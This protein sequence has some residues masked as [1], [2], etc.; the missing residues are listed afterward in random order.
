MK[1]FFKKLFTL[2][3]WKRWF[4][5]FLSFFT[6]VFVISYTS[7]QYISKNINKSIE[8]GGGAEV[9][10]QVK[11]LDDKV[12][13]KNT[14][15]NADQ[16]IFTR[17]T[18][19]SG[20]NGTSVSIEGE[21][22]IR[23]SRN[24][25]TDNRKLESFISEIVTKPLLTITDA[26]NKPLFYDGKFVDNGSLDYGNEVN[27]APPFKPESAQ[28]RPNPNNPSQNEVQIEL[29]NTD[30]ELEWSKAT[31]YVSKKPFGKNRILIWS[32]I[33]GLIK[34]AK[35]QYPDEWKNAKE[36]VFNFVHVNENPNPAPLQ[37]NRPATPVL[38]QYQ[39]D[40]KKYLISDARVQQALN[41]S[42]FVINGNFSSAEAKQLALN[43]NFGT[44]DYKLD[45]LSASF[46]SQTKSDSAFTSAWIA[47]VVAISVIALFMIVN[48]GLL[49]VLSTISLALYIFLTLLFFTIVRGEYS[50]ITIA[51]LVIGIGMNVDANIISFEILKTKIYSGHTVNKSNAYANKSSLSTIL[52]SNITTLIAGLILF[53]FG[54]KSI[55]SFSITLIFS[56]IFTLLVIMLFT[57]LM[58]SLVLRT[59]FFDKRKYLLGVRSKYLQKYER[60]YTSVLDKP[61]YLAWNKYTR[62]IPLGMFILAILIFAIFAGI[63]QSFVGGLNLSIEFSGGTNIL[64]ENSDPTYDL[65]D[66]QK[67]EAIIKFL[68]QQGIKNNASQILMHPLNAEN[69]VF[70]IEI[71]TQQDLTSVIQNLNTNLAN[72]FSN[73]KFTTYSISTEEARSLILNAIL[74]V[75]VAI[76][77]VTAFAFI[78][79]KWTF[80][81]AIIVSLLFNVLMVIFTFIIFHV[82]LSP[83]IV[84]A[85]LSII[86][87][88]IN[89]TIVIFDKIK[90]IFRELPYTEV[91]DESRVKRIATQAI[92][93][94]IKRSLLTS[95]STIFA[96]FVLM[97]FYNSIDILFSFAMFVGVIFGTF[98]SLFIATTIW[99]KLE[100]K[101]NKK[102]AK[103]IDVGYWKVQKISEQTFANINDY[104]K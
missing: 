41:G 87:Y 24:N 72:Q 101:R 28:A 16:E 104:S 66:K 40:A 11:T 3:N 45:F 47:V 34:L 23:I 29:K 95:L 70:N 50:P 37:N 82:Q 44:A 89:D 86:G 73:L 20:L 56:I 57:K 93:E 75:V 4:I 9:L 43:I 58:T 84:V 30:A 81:L 92:K 83:T 63:N 100:T 71:K 17:L 27:W 54:T 12:P 14:V 36:N 59:G 31:D 90:E 6:I 62:W 1:N 18:G 74:S 25:I 68:E 21:G 55:K 33:S 39:F 5:A 94:T 65:I 98:S 22:R 7:Q 8:Y 48:Y 96:I 19:G 51:A 2:N 102:K 10:V 78:R 46:V 67:G 35:T 88:S 79:F 32:N 77:F 49:G 61:D 13:N 69:S 15:K 97:I 99:V 60:G 42:S 26:D 64:I 76:A 53:F 85:L 38:K 52:D 80:S 91:S 103:R